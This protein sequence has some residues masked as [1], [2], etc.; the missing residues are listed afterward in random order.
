MTREEY[1]AYI[2]GCVKICKIKIDNIMGTPYVYAYGNTLLCADPMCSAFYLMELE[3]STQEIICCQ[4]AELENGIT[5]NR[6]IY[7]IMYRSLSI[8]TNPGLVFRQIE[9]TNPNDTI[10]TKS[11]DNAVRRLYMYS[12]N[13]EEYFIHYDFYNMMPLAKADTYSIE[14][15]KDN[16]SGVENTFLVKYII[17]K[18]KPKCILQIFRR[19]LDLNIG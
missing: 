13:P 9:L 4:T 11:D 7:N 18:K 1:I 5:F 10:P 8:I 2:L 17:Y 14:V 6:H 15:A 3:Y 19:I 12:D 16:F